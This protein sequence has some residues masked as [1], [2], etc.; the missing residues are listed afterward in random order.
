MPRSRPACAGR[1]RLWA[2]CGDG[3]WRDFAEELLVFQHRVDDIASASCQAGWQFRRRPHPL[4]FLLSFCFFH[5][6]PVARTGWWQSGVLD[7]EREQ[8]AGVFTELKEAGVWVDCASQR[9]GRVPSPAAP[10]LGAE[11]MSVGMPDYPG[12][13]L[14]AWRNSSNPDLISRA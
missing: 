13:F 2:L 6:V 4:I 7:D 8:A 1:L 12:V 11:V 9:K 5:D 3:A 14:T 10:P